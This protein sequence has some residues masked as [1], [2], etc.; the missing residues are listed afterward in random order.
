MTHLRKIWQTSRCEHELLIAKMHFFLRKCILQTRA[1]SYP[2]LLSCARFS[3]DP[4]ECTCEYIS[5]SSGASKGFT[6]PTVT[7]SVIFCGDGEAL[8]QLRILQNTVTFRNILSLENMTG[9]SAQLGRSVGPRGPKAG[10]RC[11]RLP[12]AAGR[13]TGKGTSRTTASSSA[14][15]PS[16]CSAPSVRRPSV[17]VWRN[18]LLSNMSF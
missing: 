14:S 15:G 2:T 16:P 8:P 11:S 6:L 10:T 18:T 3:L 9:S 12:R 13:S 7:C 5:V 17:Q 4:D 1:S